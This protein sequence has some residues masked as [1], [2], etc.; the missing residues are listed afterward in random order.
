MLTF[1]PPDSNYAAAFEQIAVVYDSVHVRPSDRDYNVSIARN[2]TLYRLSATVTGYV[3]ARQDDEHL[4]PAAGAV[5]HIVG[6]PGVWNTTFQTTCDNNGRFWLGNLPAAGGAMMV[7]LPWSAGTL[8]CG[9]ASQAVNLTMDGIFSAP[10]S[11]VARVTSEVTVLTNN[12]ASG[13]FPVDNNIVL[14]FNQALQDSSLHAN[15]PTGAAGNIPT[16]TT[17]DATGLLADRRSAAA[18]SPLHELR[19]VRYRAYREQRVVHLRSHHR[20][21]RTASATADEQPVGNRGRRADQRRPER[22]AGVP[23]LPRHRY[24]LSEHRRAR[25]AR[26]RRHPAGHGA[27]RPITARCWGRP[28]AASCPTR[29]TSRS[30]VFAPP[31]RKT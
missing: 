27:G 15:S 25:P 3:Y 23:V 26:G 31:S 7:V 13:D 12:I 8:T 1:Y 5:V 20:H 30:S 9:S 2:V 22:I 19:A 28:W 6:I 14:V 29:Y 10:N 11:I 24:G 17:L 18:A 4:L 16:L 21:D